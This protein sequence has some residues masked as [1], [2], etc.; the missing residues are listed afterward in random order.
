MEVDPQISRLS[1][2]DNVKTYDLMIGIVTGRMIGLEQALNMVCYAHGKAKFFN[3]LNIQAVLKLNKN[4]RG[5]PKNTYLKVVVTSYERNTRV[6]KV[7]I[8]DNDLPP[9]CRGKVSLGYVEW[10][11]SPYYD[12][13]SCQGIYKDFTDYLKSKESFQCNSTFKKMAMKLNVKFNKSSSFMPT[14]KKLEPLQSDDDDEPDFLDVDEV[15]IAPSVSNNEADLPQNNVKE[16]HE[17]IKGFLET[18]QQLKGFVCLFLQKIRI[19]TQIIFNK[20]SQNKIL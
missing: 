1:F 7:S 14:L 12:N 11:K 3:D 16:D 5:W 9:A 19:S 20:N 8:N 18:E 6:L 2:Y 13:I 10:L 17:L 15:E 4:E